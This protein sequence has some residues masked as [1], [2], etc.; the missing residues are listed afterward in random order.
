MAIFELNVG[1]GSHEIDISFGRKNHSKHSHETDMF[2]SIEK[3]QSRVYD[4]NDFIIDG[5]Y[6]SLVCMLCML[7]LSIEKVS[8]S[9][10]CFE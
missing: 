5:K 4:L 7:F 2:L 3:G 1:R 10:V 6:V 8:V 9:C